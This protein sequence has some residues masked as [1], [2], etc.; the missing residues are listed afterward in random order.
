MIVTIIIRYKWWSSYA[1]IRKKFS[2]T[3][4]GS[5]VMKQKIN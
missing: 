3:E 2:I 1:K 5:Y 4:V